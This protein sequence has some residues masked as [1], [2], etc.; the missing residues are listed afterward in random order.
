MKETLKYIKVLNWGYEGFAPMTLNTDFEK[1]L[2]QVRER[3]G[4][5]DSLNYDA[6]FVEA[7]SA[8]GKA[9]L[10]KYQSTDDTIEYSL[11]FMKDIKGLLEMLQPDY[12][13]EIDKSYN[14]P[15]PIW[16]RNPKRMFRWAFDAIDKFKADGLWTDE[17]WREY[18]VT[19]SQIE[20][21][22]EDRLRQFATAYD[23]SL[24]GDDLNQ[25]PQQ[26][27]QE[28][29]TDEAKRVFSKTL[30]KGLIKVDGNKYKWNDSA[31]LYGY[32]VDKTS[33]FLNIRHSNNRIPWKKYGTI[34]TNHSE[35]LTTA[36]QAVNDYKNKELPPPEGDDIVNGI[37][38]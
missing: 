18:R 9:N 34:I 27:A 24:D 7:I 20:K 25:E 6:L 35:I 12:L 26:I 16:Q 21:G 11:H 8:N 28:L 5:L 13:I 31:S 38:K 4:L 15:K 36:K 29:E 17:Q 14:P 1:S 32:F 10:L 22:F 30:S 37:C 3:L 2:Q 33:D 19:L 23:Y